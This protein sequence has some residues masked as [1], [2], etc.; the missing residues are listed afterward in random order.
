MNNLQKLL[1]MKRLQNEANNPRVIDGYCIC[2]QPHHTALCFSVFSLDAGSVSFCVED[3]GEAESYFT[4]GGIDT[5]R[6]KAVLMAY[7]N[8]YGGQ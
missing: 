6:A 3:D 4:T 7:L 2:L 8:T 1:E 5:E